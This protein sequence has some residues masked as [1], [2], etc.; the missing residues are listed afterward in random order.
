MNHFDYRNGVLHAEDVH[1]SELAATVGTPFYCYSTATLERH[2][3][4]FARGLCRRRSADLLRHEGELQP[5]GAAHAG[6]A[7]APALD[8][9]SEGELRRALA[10]GMP[11]SKIVFS[12]VG[13]TEREMRAR[14]RRRHPLLQRRVRARARRCSR[15]SRRARARPRA[16]AIRV[17]PDVDAKTHAKIT[18]GKSENKFGIPIVHAREVYARAAKLPGHRGRPASTCI[19]AARSPTSPRWRSRSACLAELVQ[20]LRADGHAIE[21]RRCRRRPRHPLPHGR[22][23][24]AGSPP[25]MPRWS[26]ASA[27]QSRLHAHVRA[28]PHHRRQ[29][30]HPRRAR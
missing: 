29:C 16:I 18:T 30:R 26:S 3:R 27:R 24:A 10:A 28:G 8:V 14:A 21:P 6:E 2:Y 25:P 12:G 5:V 23:A 13:K 17:N 7:R 20:T 22:R 1:L 4:V 11:A 9:V 19:S 15:R